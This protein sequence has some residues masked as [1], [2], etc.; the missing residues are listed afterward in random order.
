MDAAFNI[1]DG[2]SSFSFFIMRYNKPLVTVSS[3]W[4]KDLY[5]KEVEASAILLALKEVRSSGFPEIVLLLDAKEV[6]VCINRKA[7]LVIN[8]IVLDIKIL[9]LSFSS[10]KFLHI[11]RTVNVV[12]YV[13]A[14]YHS[15]I[16]K[17][18]LQRTVWFQHWLS[19]SLLN[20]ISS[21]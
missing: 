13:L 12:D 19:I 11:P 20:R 9:S 21:P 1:K 4:T 18:I 10:I 17:S 8:P 5:S 3:I 6:V 16:D 15:S 7:D 14:K 2:K